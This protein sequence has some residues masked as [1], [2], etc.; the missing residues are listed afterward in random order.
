MISEKL[1][2]ASDWTLSWAKRGEAMPPQQAAELA[3]RMMD[4]ASQVRAI[5]NAPLRL[6]S[7]E[8]R[9]QFHRLRENHDAE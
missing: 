9:L 1:Q 8:V 5:E 4:M 6:D 7:P 3:Q 2:N